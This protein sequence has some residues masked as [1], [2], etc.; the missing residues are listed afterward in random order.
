M[1][2]SFAKPWCIW[3]DAVVKNKLGHLE[4]SLPVD[5]LNINLLDLGYFLL[6]TGGTDLTEHEEGMYKKN[7]ADSTL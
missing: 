2:S 3:C 6:I 1:S 7:H 4:A 5:W